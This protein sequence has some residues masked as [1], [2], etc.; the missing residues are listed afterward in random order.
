EA[1]EEL[2]GIDLNKEEAIKRLAGDT[3]LFEQFCGMFADEIPQLRSKFE[4]TLLEGDFEKLRKQAHYLKGSA[5]MI[6]AEHVT[7]Y[8]AALELSARDSKDIREVQR[9]YQLMAAQLDK[10]QVLL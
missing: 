4:E 2:T 7:H 3:E 6:G 9:L 8:A 10:L 5:A 1:D